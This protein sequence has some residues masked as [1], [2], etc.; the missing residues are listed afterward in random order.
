MK[1]KG[2][3]ITAILLLLLVLAEWVF[4]LIYRGRLP[5]SPATPMGNVT[6]VTLPDQEPMTPSIN[7]ASVSP[8]PEL[9]S[10]VKVY[11]V[12]TRSNVLG[13]QSETYRE[14]QQLIAEKTATGKVIT[15]VATTDR[16]ASD[17]SEA[18]V[19]VESDGSYYLESFS[20]SDEK[21]TFSC[22]G[23]LPGYLA[24]GRNEDTANLSCTVNG[25]SVGNFT[26][27]ATAGP[28]TPLSFQNK[29]YQ[30][31]ELTIINTT[32][33]LAHGIKYTAAPGLGLYKSEGSLGDLVF[34][35]LT[36]AQAGEGTNTLISSDND[37]LFL[38]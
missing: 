8:L 33:P 13:A 7:N 10:A 36:G 26:G 27:Q 30:V 9:A 1:Y 15:I 22:T 28:L 12:F 21:G 25:L 31:R 29:V 5:S 32:S 20:A 34:G 4:I 35:Q 19:I 3:T 14:T 38:P 18:K 24:V 6:I 2:L 17:R 23:R 11:E 37:T 16:S